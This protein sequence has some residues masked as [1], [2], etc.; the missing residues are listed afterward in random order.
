LFL[1]YAEAGRYIPSLD[2]AKPDTTP[3]SVLLNFLA[4]AEDDTTGYHLDQ[5]LRLVDWLEPFHNDLPPATTEYPRIFISDAVGFLAT[6]LE[7]TRSDILHYLLTQKE[8]ISIAK[9]QNSR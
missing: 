7:A 9:L 3:A 1:Q 2:Y 6:K 8:K 5:M 4:R